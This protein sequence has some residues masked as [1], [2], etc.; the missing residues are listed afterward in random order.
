MR[1]EN[2]VEDV[3][4]QQVGEVLEEHGRVSAVDVA[5]VACDGHLTRQAGASVLKLGV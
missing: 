3:V 1:L 2:D 4:L 5:M